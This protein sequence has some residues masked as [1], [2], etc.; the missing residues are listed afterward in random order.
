MNNKDLKN[1][2]GAIHIFTSCTTCYIPK[3]RVLA[4]SV[5]KF[6]PSITF[7]LVLSDKL[8]DFFDLQNE[9]FDSVILIEELDIDNLEQWIFKHSVVEICTAVKPLAFCKIF[10]T[11]SNCQK[12]IFLDPDT[13]IFSSL[14][15]LLDCLEDNSILLTP[16]QLEPEK[17]EEKII[18]NELAILRHGI[19]NLGFIAVKASPEGHK[20]IDWWSDRCLNFCFIDPAN[21]IYTDQRWIDLVP[22]YFPDFHIIRDPGCN[23]ANWNLSN[24]VLTGDINSQ[25]LVNQSPL[26]FYHFSS[27]QSIMSDKHD[28]INDTSALLLQWYE[29]KCMAMGN[30]KYATLDS[31]YNLFDNGEPI[32]NQARITYRYSRKL[33]KLFPNPYDTK[34][35]KHSFFE[36]LHLNES[37]QRDI[38]SLY[39]GDLEHINHH[40][41]IFALSKNIDLM[42]QEINGVT[43]EM[44]AMES[45]K[46]WKLRTI[47]FIVKGVF[48]GKWA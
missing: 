7:H 31:F 13:A 42:K 12:I 27:S 21:G 32:S 41:K 36:W 37:I 17:T 43:A 15:G 20:F 24:R 44:T 28:V 19:F 25:I 29:N 16:H 26:V 5:K 23:V 33:Q 10:S 6:H 1:L 46:F 39:L 45:S 40:E 38:N 9:D 22:S 3:A 4:E 18:D 8:P 30:L 48:K 35:Q 14:D 47:W 2:N 11:Y 34:T